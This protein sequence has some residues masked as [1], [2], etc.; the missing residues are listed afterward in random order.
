MNIINK[1]ICKLFNHRMVKTESKYYT[2]QT[3]SRCGFQTRISKLM[4][5]R[6]ELMLADINRQIDSLIQESKKNL[7]NKD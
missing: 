2:Y 7:D 1:L 6:I 3:C 4:A 5:R